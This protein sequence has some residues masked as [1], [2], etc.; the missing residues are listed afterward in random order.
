MS[1][2]YI[3]LGGFTFSSHLTHTL[4]QPIPLDNNLDINGVIN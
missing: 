1:V 4:Q 3:K 2:G